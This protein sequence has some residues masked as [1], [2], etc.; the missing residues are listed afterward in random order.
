MLFSA[1]APAPKLTIKEILVLGQ[2]RFLQELDKWILK[3]K[4]VESAPDR[5]QILL[6]FALDFMDRGDS[7]AQKLLSGIVLTYGRNYPHTELPA[8]LCMW[9]YWYDIVYGIESLLPCQYPIPDEMREALKQE[10]AK[11]GIAPI[12]TKNNIKL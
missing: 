4:P 1:I 9:D 10:F 7:Q 8:I 6:K 11:A 5:V 2:I 12:Q 3:G